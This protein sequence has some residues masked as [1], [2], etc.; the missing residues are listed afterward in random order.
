MRGQPDAP[1]GQQQPRLVTHHTVQPRIGCGRFGPCAVVHAAQNDQ[2][3]PLHPRLERAPDHHA[4]KRRV[5]VAY[6]ARCQQSADQV[7]IV[8]RRHG[9]AQR[10]LVRQGIH[11]A[12][13]FG[14][15]LFRPQSAAVC[16]VLPAC[17]RLGQSA[18]QG[19]PI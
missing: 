8:R 13:C 15:G 5:A 1:F 11:D 3:G 6:F 14:T 17:Q 18:V 4:G 16:A 7:G 19:D 2:I 9:P 10:G 12:P